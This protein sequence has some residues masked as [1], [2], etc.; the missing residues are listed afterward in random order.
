MLIM[1]NNVIT[2]V[3][4]TCIIICN[5]IKNHAVYVN[6]FLGKVCTYSGELNDMLTVIEQVS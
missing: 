1:I 4:S 3:K 5:Q 2:I 6:L